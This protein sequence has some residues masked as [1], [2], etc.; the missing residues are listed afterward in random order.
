MY[1][2]VN[3]EYPNVYMN[4]NFYAAISRSSNDFKWLLYISLK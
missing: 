2:L 3:D 1:T 4:T